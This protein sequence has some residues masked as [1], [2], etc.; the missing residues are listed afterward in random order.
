MATKP[1]KVVFHVAEVPARFGLRVMLLFPGAG[2]GEKWGYDV[3]EGCLQLVER[4]R[5]LRADSV[6]IARSVSISRYCGIYWLL[7]DDTVWK[8]DIF[9]DLE[10]SW[11]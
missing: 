6:L 8:N 3:L 10:K 9:P 4:L 11:T 1:L 2:V 5:T 7:T